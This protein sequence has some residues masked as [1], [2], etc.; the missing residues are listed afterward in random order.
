MEDA[1]LSKFMLRG[2]S[3][4]EE[5]DV[6]VEKSVFYYYYVSLFCVACKTNTVILDVKE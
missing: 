1:A 4:D 5:I 2:F 6:V 3:S